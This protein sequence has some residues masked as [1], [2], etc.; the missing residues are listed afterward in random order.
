MY[1]GLPHVCLPNLYYECLLLPKYRLIM[2]SQ[3]FYTVGLQSSFYWLEFISLQSGVF[4]HRTL[5]TVTAQICSSLLLIYVPVPEHYSLTPYHSD[6]AVT[7][8][9]IC[10]SSM[11]GYWHGNVVLSLHRA[12]AAEWLEEGPSTCALPTPIRMRCAGYERCA[13]HHIRAKGG[14][15]LCAQSLHV[16]VW[17]V[18]MCV[19]KMHGWC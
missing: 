15:R 2:S 8:S 13:A 18:C 1:F 19:F 7:I 17:H 6:T 12:N 14:E 5:Q 3:S 10:G 4:D 16:S 11:C 9:S